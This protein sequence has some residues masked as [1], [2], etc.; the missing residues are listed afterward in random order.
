MKRNSIAVLPAIFAA[1]VL[2]SPQGHERSSQSGPA[3]I[4]VALGVSAAHAGP[5]V[6]KKRRTVRRHAYYY[7]LPRG[8]AARVIGGIRYHYCGGIYYQPLLD[9]AG[10]SAYII[11]NP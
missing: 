8:C 9:D 1:G 5:A 11:V 2:L 4:G 7:S 6:R 3:G 10:K